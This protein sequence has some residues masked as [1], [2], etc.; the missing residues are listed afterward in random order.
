MTRVPPEFCDLPALHPPGEA[1]GS[2]PTW[3]TGEDWVSPPFDGKRLAIRAGFETD[4][5]SIPRLF[6]LTIGHPFQWPLLGP[7]LCHDALYAA[8]LVSR[9]HA[10]WLFLGWMQRMGIAWH[11]RNRIWLAVRV[12]GAVV[13]GRHTPASV[14]Q[15]GRFAKLIQAD[16]R[17]VIWPDDGEWAS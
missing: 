11:K 6:W 8:E 12:G 5:A 9:S 2:L 14:K 1:G 10:D 13:Y 17:E 7:A 16:A 4:G 15:A 3:R